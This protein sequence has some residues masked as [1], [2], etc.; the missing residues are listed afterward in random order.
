MPSP[1]L[2]STALLALLA[3]APASGQQAAVRIHDVQGAAHRSPL[4]GSAVADVPGVV[5][6]VGPDGFHL[7]DPEPDGSDA[8]S[9]GVFVF[10]GEAP[11]VAT[12]DAVRVDGRVAERRPGGA[13]ENLSTTEI[14][15]TAVTAAGT[16]SVA[17]AVVGRGGRALP[18]SIVSDGAVEARFD[19]R[20]E[21]IDFHESLE[22][23]LVEVRSA[24]AVGPTSDVGELPV[25]SGPA[26]L[27]T[28]RGGLLLRPSDP[29]PERILLDDALAGPMPAADVRDRLGPVRAVVGYSFGAFKY[30]VLEPP[31]VRSGGL[32][33]E[34][35]VAARG[36]R[37]AVATM[38]VE[39][40]D[41]RDPAATYRRLA[42]ILVEALRSPDLVAV[43]E[44]Q[45]DDGA[46][47]ASRAG[48]A[49]T[50]RRLVAAIARA[51]GPAYSYRQIDPRPGRDGGEP[52]GNIRVGF[53]FRTDRGLAFVDRPGGTAT[54]GTTEDAARP[55]A[56]L[57]RSPGRVA[58]RSAAFADS[59][60]PLA[61]E[62]TWRGRR[63][64]A[65]AN[66]F[67][68]KGGDDP[69]L[70]RFQPPRRPTDAQRRRQATVVRDFVRRLLRADV[71]AA[72]VV[73][74][75]LNDFQFSRTL[76]ILE[77]GG[78]LTNLME[79][80]PPRE[81]YSYVFEGNS[82]ALDHVLVS[83]SLARRAPRY[84]SVHVNAE[85]AE[86]A[87]DHDPQVALLRVEG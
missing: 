77:D 76:A 71:G 4:A 56:Q 75:D 8:T 79:R 86:Q 10:T 64:V 12:G 72:V 2:L 5:T 6:A 63:F 57:T 1:R 37:L 45:D 52:G 43:E 65:V 84:D 59:R 11:D 51:G 82:Q 17:P 70:G 48:A 19:P 20:R 61:G 16:G 25:V 55:G 87:S 54:A 50:W 34:Q 41:G 28:P 31:A 80:L 40:L 3:A 74:G 60:K 24:V 44:V 33:P 83:R 7:Q 81:R 13:A 26:S 38:N 62:F 18:R 67:S 66:H 21:G 9:E 58:P 15:A 46:A 53:L 22:G 73:L 27:R 78:R 29:N 23:M 42:R 68:S 35:T 49:R 85:L 14:A 32:A 36:D 47:S 39:N 30:Q 69:L